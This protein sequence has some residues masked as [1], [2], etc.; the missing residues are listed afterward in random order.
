MEKGVPED[1]V[2]RIAFYRVKNMKSPIY[3]FSQNIFDIKILYIYAHMYVYIYKYN[4]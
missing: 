2:N 3:T 1:Y 4:E